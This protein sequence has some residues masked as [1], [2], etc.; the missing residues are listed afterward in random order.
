MLEDRRMFELAFA[1]AAI[2]MAL[3]GLDGHWLKVNHAL[4]R[5]L[6]YSQAELL[7]TTAAALTHRDDLTAHLSKAQALLLGHIPSYQTEKRYIHKNGNVIW[8]HVTASMVRKS[9]GLPDFLI[10]QIQDTTKQRHAATERE[11]FFNRSSQFLGV[12]ST[13]KVLTQVNRA[14]ERAFG[15]K[16]TDIA[17]AKKISDFIHPDDLALSLAAIEEVHA[18]NANRTFTNRCLLKG[19]KYKWIEWVTAHL[20]NGDV[21]VEG[22][23]V[24]ER[25]LTLE[26]LATSLALLKDVADHVP[27]MIGYFDIQLRNRYANARA[28]EWFGKPAEQLLGM[29]LRD[30]IGEP[31]F[32]RDRILIS[33]ALQ[34]RPQAYSSLLPNQNGQDHVSHMVYLVPSMPEDRVTGIYVLSL[35]AATASKIA[36]R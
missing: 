13:D 18:G 24:T 7:G 34:G 12:I 3:V 4:C 20:F 23:D 30:I 14:W 10:A 26:S 36:G 27:A 22:R 6:G 28:G 2:G 32:K 19:G 31:A 35:D 33:M 5:M 25:I 11:I 1:E 9:N 17:V 8:V 15:W 21:Y 29:H 16:A